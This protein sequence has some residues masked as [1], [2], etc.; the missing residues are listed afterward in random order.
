M[1]WIDKYR[2]KT[3]DEIVGNKDIIQQFKNMVKKDLLR[4]IIITG[5]VGL[6][7]TSTMFCLCNT[8]L[9]NPK[10]NL[11]EINMSID[12]NINDI[13][14]ML[15][16]FIKKRSDEKK[17]IILEEVD[18]LPEA[19]QH[20]IT[21]MMNRNVIFF[22]TCNGIDKLISPLQSKCLLLNFSEL[23]NKE[24]CEGITKILIKENVE[25]ELDALMKIIDYSNHDM[26][27]AIN[28][29]QALYIGY[30]KI[31]KQTVK[32]ILSKS[33]KTLLRKYI[34]LCK[35]KQI[36]NA[37]EY[38]DELINNGYSQSDIFSTLF[39]L[40]RKDEYEDKLNFLNLV[41][42]YHVNLLSGCRSKIQIYA[43]TYELCT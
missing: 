3:F 2:P 14:T 12:R 4:N 7:K 31:T 25:Y 22:L 28:H 21:S 8:Y 19:T 39:Y 27:F 9:T 20:A 33:L 36:D 5:S 18:N 10:E 29:V 11:L 38:I 37:L 15:D 24:I 16:E 26:R 30:G 34:N 32:H 35:D 41:G 17:I 1:L 40:L 23:S 13:R 42:K 43:L 6:G